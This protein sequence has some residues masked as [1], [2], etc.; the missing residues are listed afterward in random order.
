MLF[1]SYS[2]SKGAGLA[3]KH[4]DQLLTTV[5]IFSAVSAINCRTRLCLLGETM[6]T[7]LIQLLGNRT[8]PS[9]VKVR[10]NFD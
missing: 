6:V 5:N 9:K 10:E 8:Q 4:I 3:T 7:T 2:N 1:I